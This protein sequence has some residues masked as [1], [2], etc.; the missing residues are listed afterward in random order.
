MVTK[1][2][3]KD[4]HIDYVLFTFTS[5]LLGIIMVVEMPQEVNIMRLSLII[6]LVALVVMSCSRPT[7]VSFRRQILPILHDHC[8]SCHKP[9]G[10]GY[11]QSGLD[12]TQYA[13]LIRGTKFGQV[14][15]PGAS[16]ASTLIRLVEHQ[17]DQSINMPHKNRM[18]QTAE[19]NSLR[20]WVD[21]GAKNN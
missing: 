21:Q 4:Y 17:A 13:S 1:N 20:K 15:S 14:V 12:L 7:E 10:I 3:V 8:V 18:L 9:G 2:P 19:I 16:Y 5:E 6:M 11:E